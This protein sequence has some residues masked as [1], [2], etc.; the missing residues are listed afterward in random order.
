LV[1]WCDTEYFGSTNPHQD[2]V[3]SLA[4]ADL[5]AHQ[6]KLLPPLSRLLDS[7]C[8]P[9]AVFVDQCK[10]GSTNRLPRRNAGQAENLGAKAEGIQSRNRMLVAFTSRCSDQLSVFLIVASPKNQTTPASVIS[11]ILPRT[12]RSNGP[13][14]HG[15]G[16]PRTSCIV[17]IVGFPT[18]AHC[19]KA[20]RASTA[21]MPP[22]LAYF[23]Q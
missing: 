9:G 23:G 21:Y 13:L 16:K 20:F 7:T 18:P 12:L 3:H 15:A 14:A 2:L 10:H 8:L 22:I 6:R 11:R 5:S 4:F 19:H 17:L 1:I